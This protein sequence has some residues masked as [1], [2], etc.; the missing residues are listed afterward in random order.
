MQGCK[1]DRR[2][3]TWTNHQ[4]FYTFICGNCFCIL[5]APNLTITQALKNDLKLYGRELVQGGISCR[6]APRENRLPTQAVSGD[7]ER[8]R[9]AGGETALTAAQPSSRRWIRARGGDDA[10]HQAAPG[11]NGAEPLAGSAEA[12]APGF[13]PQPRGACCIQLNHRSTLH[14]KPYTQGKCGHPSVLFPARS[15]ETP[16]TLP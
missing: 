11:S 6:F 9:G 14:H 8:L 15:P 5:M 1:L 16:L 4:P 12:F 13:Q 7:A 3:S 2:L 10:P